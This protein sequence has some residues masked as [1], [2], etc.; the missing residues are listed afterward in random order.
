MARI[1]LSKSTLIRIRDTVES[2]CNA[3]T[4][5]DLYITIDYEKKNI[6]VKNKLTGQ[7]FDLNCRDRRLIFKYFEK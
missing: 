4:I 2:G 6:T 5:N 1:E 7:E 3:T